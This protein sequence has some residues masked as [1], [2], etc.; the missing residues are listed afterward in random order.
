MP[1]TSKRTQ[2]AAFRLPVE[3]YAIIERRVKGKRS[4]WNTVS[5][6]LR[7]RVCYDISR[8]HRRKAQ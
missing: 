6:Y 7:E 4:R 3:I 2:V 1:N 5:E 8:S